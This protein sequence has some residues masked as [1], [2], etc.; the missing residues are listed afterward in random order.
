M[1][2]RPERAALFELDR[3]V[4]RSP[5]DVVPLPVER[6]LAHHERLAYTT[7][8]AWWDVLGRLGIRLL[9][10]REYEHLLVCVG[11]DDR[12]RPEVSYLPLPHPSGIAADRDSGAVWV[13][14]TRNP[15][16]VLTLHGRHERLLPA[17]SLFMPGSLY[18]HD[19][20]VIDG[21]LHGNAVGKNHVVEIAADG[22]TRAA[23]WPQSMDVHGHPDVRRNWLQLNSIAASATLADSFFTASTDRRQR[24]LPG[25]PRFDPTHRG[26]VYSGRTRDVVARGLTR[27]HSARL[28]GTTLWLDDSGYGTVG[29]VHD[30]RYQSVQR[31]PGWTRGLCITDG[32]AFVGTSHVL[33]GFEH[34]APGV[35]RSLCGVHAIDTATG[36]VLGSVRW[37][38]GNQIFAIEW[39]QA[40]A[41][42]GL[43]YSRR[44]SPRSVERMFFA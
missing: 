8:G 29:V 42:A 37:S 22:D 40:S 24:H 36:S 34:Y 35:G 15:N 13:A 7:T 17:Q 5:A 19:L 9:V 16:Q 20:A 38:G 41:F 3:R 43:P 6:P 31:L 26:V 28:D 21:R 39:L 10:S 18:L 11:L 33:P 23:W 14:L 27:P 25:H 1:S 12:G 2:A 4:L 30:G 44:R 32:V